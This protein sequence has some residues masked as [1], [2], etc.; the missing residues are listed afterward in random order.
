[1]LRFCLRGNRLTLIGAR[2]LCQSLWRGAARARCM[3]V[4]I[5]AISAAA[6]TAASAQSALPE[7]DVGVP[8]LSGTVAVIPFTNI[9]GS[10]SDNWISVGIAETVMADLE[11]VSALSVMGR[12]AVLEAAR[13][14]DIGLTGSEGRVLGLGRE[15]GAAWIVWGGYQRLGDRLRITARLV[16]VRTGAVIGAVTVDGGV[17]EI[18]ALQDRIVPGLTGDLDP[19]AFD[20]RA[21]SRH[22]AATSPEVATA[23]ATRDWGAG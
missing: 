6:P 7:S 13:G 2:V 9:S 3:V 20:S 8:V 11:R 19:D 16:D 15:L 5:V 4:C 23:G 14:Q 17:D 12:G 21:A 22:P 10:A 1:M 18:F